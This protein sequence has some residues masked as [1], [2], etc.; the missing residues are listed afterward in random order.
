MKMMTKEIAKKLPPLYATEEIPT[1]DKT[2]VVKFFDPCGSWTWYAVEGSAM[3]KGEKVPLSKVPDPDGVEIIFFGWVQG[4]CPEWG[5]F[6]T[7]ELRS[8]RGP[9]GI[10][11][12]R[13]RWWDPKPMSEV[14]GFGN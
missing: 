7:A 5:Y 12:E 2:A 9:L 3:I 8:Y 14:P 4:P 10:G 13:D 11:I 1:D 6:S